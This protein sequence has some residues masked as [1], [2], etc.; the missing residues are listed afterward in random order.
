LDISIE[1]CTIASEGDGNAHRA[2]SRPYSHNASNTIATGVVRVGLRENFNLERPGVLLLVRIDKKCHGGA[3]RSGSVTMTQ[4]S[5]EK[6]GMGDGTKRRLPISMRRGS[7]RSCGGSSLRRSA[8]L[9]CEVASRDMGPSQ[10][11][12]EPQPWVARARPVQ[13][14]RARSL[15]AAT[16]ALRRVFV[17][18]N[19]QSRSTEHNVPLLGNIPGSRLQRPRMIDTLQTDPPVR[20][21]K[22]QSLNTCTRY[23]TVSI[24]CAM[25]RKLPNFRPAVAV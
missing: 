19:V 25:T 7:E 23:C 2:K 18:G 3:V 1:N 22:Q 12:T 16:M 4:A 17:D 9:Y 8:S 13:C 6:T 15:A 24:R 20:C 11:A 21:P 5:S 14:S 10:S